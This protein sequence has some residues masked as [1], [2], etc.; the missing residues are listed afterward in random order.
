MEQQRWEDSEKRKEETKIIEKK[1]RKNKSRYSKRH[2]NHNK[3]WSAV[4]L[5]CFVAPNGRKVGSLKR[6]L[7]SHLWEIKTCMPLWHEELESKILFKTPRVRRCSEQVWTLRYGNGAC[8]CGA[9]QIWTSKCEKH[10]GLGVL[11]GVETDR[12]TDKQASKQTNRQTPMGLLCHPWVTTTQADF[13]SLK[14]PSPPCAVLLVCIPYSIQNCSNTGWIPNLREFMEALLL[15]L[16][17][18]PVCFRRQ[19]GCTAEVSET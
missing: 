4:F 14:L 13:R 10:N 12:Q 18:W 16:D 11:L 2:K 3:S 6:Q 8:A 15:Q 19:P 5:Q 9:K 17:E 7:W 1:V